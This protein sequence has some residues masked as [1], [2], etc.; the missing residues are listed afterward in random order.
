MMETGREESIFLYVLDIN[1]N[2]MK[3][4][5]PLLCNFRKVSHTVQCAAFVQCARA[6]FETSVP[7]VFNLSI[8]PLFRFPRTFA[9][10]AKAIKKINICNFRYH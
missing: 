9:V 4:P 2:E 3:F 10:T 5:N 8:S 6:A 7:T 1:P